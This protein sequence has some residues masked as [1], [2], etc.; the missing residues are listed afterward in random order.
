MADRHRGIDNHYY[1]VTM[2]NLAIMS[3]IQDDLPAALESADEAVD[4]LETTSSRI[5]LAAALMARAYVRDAS[6]K[7][8]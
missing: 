4:A 7:R 8:S 5:E 2:L 6:G 3:T 1:G